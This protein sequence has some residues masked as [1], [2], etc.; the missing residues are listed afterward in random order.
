VWRAQVTGACLPRARIAHSYIRHADLSDAD[1]SGALLQRA[2]LE[3]STFGRANLAGADLEGALLRMAT[4]A[5]ANFSHANL[6]RADLAGAD[7]TGVRLRGERVYGVLSSAAHYDS[8]TRWPAG[9]DALKHGAVR[10][11]ED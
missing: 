11:S 4:L 9:F 3:S 5:D 2:N 1:L 10:V 6:T 7:L 8:R